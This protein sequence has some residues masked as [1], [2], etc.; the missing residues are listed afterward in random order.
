MSPS[1][2]VTGIAIGIALVSASFA[3]SMD[4]NVIYQSV[5]GLLIIII[6]LLL[7][8]A[9]KLKSMQLATIITNSQCVKPILKHKIGIAILGYLD[10]I[11][12]EAK[13]ECSVCFDCLMD[14]PIACYLDNDNKRVCRH[15]ICADCADKL[16]NVQKPQCPECR[17]EFKSYR[18]FSDFSVD[19]FDECF[20]MFDFDNSGTLDKTEV[21][22]AIAVLTPYTDEACTKFVQEMWSDWDQD[23]DGSIDKE[24]FKTVLVALQS[25]LALNDQLNAKNSIDDLPF[26]N[27]CELQSDVTD[28]MN[29][30]LLQD[31]KDKNILDDATY[32]KAVKYL[33]NNAPH[34]AGILPTISAPSFSRRV[35]NFFTPKSRRQ[36]RRG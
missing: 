12:S 21:S 6:L 29:L 13:A 8:K 14:K 30:R 31:L 23:D 28:R 19:N 1:A 33:N 32:R 10:R 22:Y 11:D 2:A 18:T 9:P 34:N 17:K 26:A 20:F 25:E 36:G 27:N 3:L 5:I 35:K 16:H 24:E 15:L 4:T 7:I